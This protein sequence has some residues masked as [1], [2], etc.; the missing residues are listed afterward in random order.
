MTPSEPRLEMSA[1]SRALA[2][3]TDPTPI[4][5]SILE[6][7]RSEF[8]GV[9]AGDAALMAAL[10]SS[11]TDNVTAILGLISGRLRIG[12]I[13]PPADFAFTDLAV[14]IGIPMSEI[15]AAYWIGL[16]HFWRRWFAIA[17]EAAARGEG[18]FDELVG[19]PTETLMQHLRETVK[20]VAAR[21]EEVSES[22]HRTA[23]DRRRMMIAAIV[24]GEP[25]FPLDDVERELGYRFT[26]VHL[27]LA[28]QAPERGRVESLVAPLADR[29]GAAGSLLSMHG[30]DTWVCWL[31]FPSALSVGD[32]SA[33][34]AALNDPKVA[35]TA[36]EPGAGVAGFRRTRN[37]A[38]AAAA[39][40]RR[41]EGID[42][43][44]W[45]R[46]VSL[47]LCLLADE[48]AAR[49]F[50]EDELGDLN[51]AGEREER[52]RQTLLA[53][54]SCGSSSVVAQ[55]LF[56]HENTVRLRVGQAQD[57]LPADLQ[58]RRAEV[59]A[60]LRLRALLGDPA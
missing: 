17:G 13:P 19:A 23:N 20:T 4:V 29:A 1:A 43:F 14:R 58:G 11:V 53:W 48:N 40:R 56:L 15:E 5:E 34:A 54:L 51:A 39:L 16:S 46:D 27:G 44:L 12:D 25:A 37:D 50:M 55:R 26:G 59:L 30:A 32:R 6:G 42:G 2:A 24:D 3:R 33:V 49:R 47:E 36:G 8:W 7:V 10:R 35:V 22:I 9:H 28:L 18:E 41:F 31:R 52:A 21:Y 45:F 38:L 60:A 57:L